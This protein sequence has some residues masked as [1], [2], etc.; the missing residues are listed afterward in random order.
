MIER[1][2]EVINEL[3]KSEKDEVIALVCE[4]AL[5]LY[6]KNKMI[7]HALKDKLSVDATQLFGDTIDLWINGNK[8]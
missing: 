2:V 5:T 8:L 1:A 4:F 3:S 6:D 7:Y